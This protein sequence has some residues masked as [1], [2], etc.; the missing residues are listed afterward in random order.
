MNDF[1]LDDLL[2]PYFSTGLHFLLSCVRYRKNRQLPDIL[3]VPEEL[4]E[5]VGSR[6][7]RQKSGRQSFP[8][9]AF[10]KMTGR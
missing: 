10:C 6:D 1:Q 8:Q 9:Y 4:W 5:S 3:L 2:L 7:R